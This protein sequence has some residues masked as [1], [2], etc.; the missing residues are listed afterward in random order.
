MR[1]IVIDLETTNSHGDAGILS[2]GAVEVDLTTGKVVNQLYA[3]LDIVQQQRAFGAVIDAG[4]V[5]WWMQQSTE[6][7]ELFRRC[8]TDGLAFNYALIA[9]SNFILG[10]TADDP[11]GDVP[12]K[13]V[14]V[15]GNGSS[16]DN[17]ILG[18]AYRRAGILQP[19][20]FWNDM[21][22]RT[23]KVMYENVTGQRFER[24]TPALAHHALEDAMAQALDL[25]D[26]FKATRGVGING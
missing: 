25:I 17:V 26:I 22:L 14:R 8:E 10:D 4:T 9:L 23:A 20:A 3:E 2:I 6:A 16:F 1:N 11:D 15:W 24:R 21:D 13:D 19:W 5:L 18:N 7:K 12:N